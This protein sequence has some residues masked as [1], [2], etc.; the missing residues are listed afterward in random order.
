MAYERSQDFSQAILESD[1]AIDLARR[2][3]AQDPEDAGGIEGLIST[4]QNH[5]S[6]L[7][8]AGRIEEAVVTIT[9]ALTLARQLDERFPEDPYY[10]RILMNTLLRFA[11]VSP[12]DSSLC[13]TVEE[14]NTLFEI[15][16]ADE[17]STEKN[18][19]STQEKLTNT[20]EQHS[21]TP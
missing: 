9:E 15:L 11:A 6:F 7:F 3:K 17:D 8:N 16:S 2:I 5:T 19:S 21:C 20:R 12:A 18:F 10:Q 14:A 1:K 13:G 4:L